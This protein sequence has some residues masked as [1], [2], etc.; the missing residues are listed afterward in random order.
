MLRRIRRVQIQPRKHV[1]DRA[2]YKAPTRQGELDHTDHTDHA[3]H[4]DE[5][6]IC[7]AWQI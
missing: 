3:D 5:G 7:P 6:S 1:L 2:D 4:T